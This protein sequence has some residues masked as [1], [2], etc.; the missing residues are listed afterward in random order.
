MTVSNDASGAVPVAATAATLQGV[1]RDCTPQGKGLGRMKAG[2]IAFV[3][4]PDMTR[5]LAEL[6]VAAQPAAVVNLDRFTTGAIPNYGPHVLLDAGIPL[7][8]AAGSGMRA[9][10][11]D[12]KK[13]RLSP[14]GEITVGKKVAGHAT[15]VS[16]ADVDSTFTDAQ[17]SLVDNMEAFF[18][19][20]IQF[21]HSEAPL[22]IDGVGAPEVGD[23]MSD[24][25]V[26]VVSPAPDTKE[27]LAGLR[28]FIAE[29][30]PVIIGVGQAADTLTEMGYDSDFIVADPTEV[31]EKSLR[32][33]A[34]VILPAET[35]G[36]APGLERI[37]D[38]GVGAMTFP[39]AT[40]S[41][42]DLAILLA[43]FHDA[44]TVVTVGQPVELDSI[45][46]D[47]GTT[48]PAA[49]LTRLKAGRK[50]V[51]STVIEHLYEKSPGGGGVAWAWAILGLLVAAAT[52]IVI[53]GLG[54][55]GTFSDNVVDTWEAV[56]R[57]VQSWFT[58]WFNQV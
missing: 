7:F 2:D 48:E 37:Q 16:R 28:N 29:F 52:I 17:R 13:V 30:T 34:R 15:P 58:S 42:T 20:T 50:I 43:V 26:L 35:D 51:D 31:S 41:P 14:E 1:L 56:S 44:E 10:V 36:Y 47:A 9:K 39:A 24:R 4:A 5:R 53:V 25:K 18:G 21:I 27:R 6:L 22:L 49:L 8:E 12:G 45:F 55:S 33:D 23:I 3:D 54:G 19:N 11:R 57:E 40:E 32:G 38:L 46:A